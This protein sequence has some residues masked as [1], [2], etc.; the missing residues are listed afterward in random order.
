MDASTKITLGGSLCAAHDELFGFEEG[1][2]F[3]LLLEIMG[4]EIASGEGMTDCD[5]ATCETL[6]EVTVAFDVFNRCD[7]IFDQS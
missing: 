3:S 7:S 1:G 5:G 2:S 4:V 6:E